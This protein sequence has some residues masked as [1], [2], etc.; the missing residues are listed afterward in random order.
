MRIT[1]G[2]I[3]EPRSTAVLSTSLNL[4]AFLSVHCLGF[5]GSG[6]AL[7]ILLRRQWEAGFDD[8]TTGWVVFRFDLAAVKADGSFGDGEAKA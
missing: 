4:H 2:Q 3:A 1:D 8:Q 7:L 5:C 6:V